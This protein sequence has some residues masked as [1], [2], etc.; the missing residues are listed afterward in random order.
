M[1]KLI[2]KNNLGVYYGKRFVQ[3]HLRKFSIRKLNVGVCSVLCLP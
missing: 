3:S 1:I 2:I